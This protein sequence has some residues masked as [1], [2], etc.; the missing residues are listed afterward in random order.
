MLMMLAI[1]IA[2]LAACGGAPA[3]QSSGS[4]AVSATAVAPTAGAASTAAPALTTAPAP[5]AAQAA[6]ATSAPL[7]D[8]NPAKPDDKT[9]GRL[10]ISN[11]VYGGDSVDMLIDGKLTVNGGV[12][13]K[14]LSGLDVS[15]YQYLMPGAYSV[16]IVPTGQG[17]DKALLGP[18]DVP[19]VAGHRYTLVMLGQLG[20]KTHKPLLIDETAAY[21]AFGPAPDSAYFRHIS[22]NN[23]KGA[24]G[25]DVYLGGL[26]R[27]E[28]VSYGAFKAAL[29]PTYTTG[30]SM[31]VAGDVSK[32]L[33]QDKVAVI[34]NNPAGGDNFDCWSGAFPGTTDTHTAAHSSELNTID[35]LQIWSDGSAKN[36]GHTPSF[37]SFLAALK[38]AGLAD[39][40]TTG[41][42]YLVFAPTDEAFAALPKD[43]RDALMAD[44]KALADL[45]HTHL[46]EGYFPYGTMGG[47]GQGF[48]RTV[49]NMRG[50]QLKVTGDDG[51]LFI[52]GKLIGETSGPFIANGTRVM[53]VPRLFRPDAK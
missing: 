38:T 35:F 10:R 17:L 31:T 43:K 5:T 52:N 16:A 49:T 37:N 33:L 23:I 28:A 15:G 9:Q 41:G 26:I 44:P 29:W 45:I 6:T 7:A 2:L 51:A 4:T 21:Q 22:I 27:E 11:C 25:I 48:N 39:K 13:Q 24:S 30:I 12:T 8:T 47:I 14:N 50:E 42:P 1:T 36:G 19:I 18:L 20:E 3:P 53:S 46:V 32:V 40:L 34:N